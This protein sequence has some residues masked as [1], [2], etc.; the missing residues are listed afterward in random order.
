MFTKA[1]L[2]R[3]DPT[4][5]KYKYIND[6]ERKRIRYWTKKEKIKDKDS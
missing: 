3:Q 1:D 5:E 4:V 6:D 2:Y